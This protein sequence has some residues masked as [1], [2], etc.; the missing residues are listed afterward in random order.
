MSNSHL[1]DVPRYD[2]SGIE[3]YDNFDV[4]I[5]A[6]VCGTPGEGGYRYAEVYEDGT[7]RLRGTLTREEPPYLPNS[8]PAQR[9]KIR[10]R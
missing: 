4:P 8:Q 7:L 1:V 10:C 3:G 9:S 6:A 5:Y 2:F